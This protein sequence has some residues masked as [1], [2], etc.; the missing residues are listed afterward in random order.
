MKMKRRII[1]FLSYVFL[2]IFSGLLV[3][4]KLGFK[5]EKYYSAETDEDA[6]NVAKINFGSRII[7]LGDVTQLN[8]QNVNEKLL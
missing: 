5:V 4:D 8:D 2:I 3:L 7:H 1:T 6:I